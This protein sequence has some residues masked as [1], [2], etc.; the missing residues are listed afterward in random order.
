MSFGRANKELFK[1]G[2]EN[3]GSEPGQLSDPS[4]LQ[5]LAN[6]SILLIESGNGQLVM[7]NRDLQYIRTIPT[8]VDGGLQCPISFCLHQAAGRLWL[9]NENQLLVY[10]VSNI[11]ELKI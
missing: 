5:T 6:G 8:P 1:Y 9:S 3:P 4:E 2:T 11:Q 7:L 10:D